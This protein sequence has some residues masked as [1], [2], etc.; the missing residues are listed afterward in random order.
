MKSK[1]LFILRPPIHAYGG[2][3]TSKDLL[4]S[5]YWGGGVLLLGGGSS[6]R[7]GGGAPPQKER[8]RYRE[9][10]PGGLTV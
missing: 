2:S 8:R 5:C 10:R 4:Y 7:G 3:M 6:T 1:D 9:Q